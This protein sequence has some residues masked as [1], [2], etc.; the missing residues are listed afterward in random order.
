MG[1][2]SKIY[3]FS[4]RASSEECYM[5]VVFTSGSLLHLSFSRQP[6][7]THILTS[8]I[9]HPHKVIYVSTVAKQTVS[10]FVF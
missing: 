10:N 7:F 8:H 5:Q 6:Y 9:A 3:Y 4:L 2:L 1:K